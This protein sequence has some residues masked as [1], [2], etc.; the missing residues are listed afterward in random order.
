M[1]M[2]VAVL[3][4]L[5]GIAAT[6]ALAEDA[7]HVDKPV[8]A[9]VPADEIKAPA[10]DLSA[11]PSKAEASAPAKSDV[12]AKPTASADELPAQVPAV[13]PARRHEATAEPQDEPACKTFLAIV[14]G[15]PGGVPECE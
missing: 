11:L 14:G 9:T 3:T 1:R 10:L 13:R 7:P 4:L 5:A 12:A 15:N 2:R 6:P 8:I